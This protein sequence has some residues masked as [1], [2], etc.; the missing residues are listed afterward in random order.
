[1]SC[2]DVGH[3]L[4]SEGGLKF[5]NHQA[6]FVDI[7]EEALFT[8]QGADPTSQ[9]GKGMSGKNKDTVKKYR[10]VFKTKLLAHNI[11]ERCQ[12]LAAQPVGSDLTQL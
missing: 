12:T 4:I 1:M 6:L 3:S 5:S 2:I 11:F 8:S 10:E 9:K 7:N